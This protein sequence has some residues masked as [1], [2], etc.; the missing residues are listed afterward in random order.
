MCNSEVGLVTL[1][2]CCKADNMNG[3]DMD[4]ECPQ[5]VYY[6]KLSVQTGFSF[7]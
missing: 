7:F 2:D 4:P 6:Y 3:A 1:K 5:E